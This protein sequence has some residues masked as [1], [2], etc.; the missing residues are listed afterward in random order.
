MTGERTPVRRSARPAGRARD[1]LRSAARVEGHVADPGG[2]NVSAWPGTPTRADSQASSVPEGDASRQ[3]APLASEPAV[4][5][6]DRWG[7]AAVLLGVGMIGLVGL[8]WSTV[9]SMVETWSTTQSFSHGFLIVPICIYLLWQRRRE[10]A[11]TNPRPSVWGIAFAVAAAFAWLLGSLAGVLVV[12]QFAFVAMVQGLFVAVVGTGPLRV[13][14]FPILYLYFAVPFGT[15]LIAPLQDFTAQFLVHM[16]RLSGMPVYLDGIFLQIPSGSFEVAEAC[17]GLRFLITS[18]ALGVVFA[19]VVYHQLWRRVL[20]IALSVIVPIIANGF[21]AYGIVMLAH[22]SDYRIAA[23]VD[24]ITYG[25]IF[26]S[27][28]FFLLLALGMSLRERSKPVSLVVSS[29][30]PRPAGRRPATSISFLAATAAV[31]LFAASASG[32]AGYSAYLAGGGVATTL[33]PPVVGAPWTALTAANASWQPT[34][35]DPDKE[36]LQTYA[37]GDRHVDLYIAYYRH[38]RQGA[39]VVH[40]LNSFAGAPPWERVGG[41][42]IQAVVDGQDLKVAYTRI[43]SPSGHRVVWHWYW[44]DGQY[45]ASPYVAKLLEV[46]A[47]LLGGVPAAAAV[48]VAAGYLD[49]PEEAFHAI[50]DFLRD[51]GPIR[52]ALEHA[53]R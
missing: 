45:T 9:S 36:S 27:I 25:L 20:F 6:D 37:D 46:K 18:V 17:A 41:G 4:R 22:Y 10:F 2:T 14:K 38:Q 35:V 8:F 50:K 33:T 11:E 12:Q 19:Y 21:R 3:S 1:R 51:T 15:S 24:H 23:G 30:A 13:A 42:H 53:S 28:V 31:L 26:L 32:Y 52:A 49:S 44:V 48:A 5:L 47:K 29:I 43:R 7:W 16:L 40:G 34:F 39:E